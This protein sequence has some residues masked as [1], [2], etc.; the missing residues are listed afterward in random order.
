M[1]RLLPVFTLL[2]GAL[3]LAACRAEDRLVAGVWNGKLRSEGTPATRVSID[4]DARVL[5]LR[6]RGSE[7]R[8]RIEGVA[9]PGGAGVRVS[10]AERG[11]RPITSEALAAGAGRF[12]RE[13]RLSAEQLGPTSWVSL[14]FD[15]PGLVIEGLEL[16]EDAKRPKLVVLGLDGLTWRVLDPLLAAGRLPHF[17]KLVE[18]GVAGELLSEKPMLSPVVWT[19]IAAGRRHGEHG[20]HDFFDAEGR[21]V[22]STQVKARRIW[23][24]AGAEAGATVGVSGWFVSWPV[25][26]VPGFML[27]DRATEWKP[28]DLDRPL[29]FH[30]AE[31]Q[32][33]FEAVVDARRERAIEEC[34]RFTSYPLLPD[35]KQRLAPADPAYERH[36][37]L[38][39]RLFRVFLRDSSFVEASVRLQAALRPDLLFVYLRGSDNVQ[40]AFWFQRAPQESI[41]PV[42]PEEVRQFGNV[43][44]AY[45][46]WLDEALGRLMA[47]ADADTT[48]VVASDHG[49]RS[50]LRERGG[51]RRQV[52]YHEPQGVFI[53]S[54]PPFKR[55][56]RV[57]PLS[58]LDLAPLWLQ[59]VGLPAAQDMPGRVP[60]E[61][62]AR[63]IREATRVASYGGRSD[64]AVSRAGEADAGIV[65]QLK[66]LGYVQE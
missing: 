8:V 6:H 20:I 59:L 27:S 30:P 17:R 18:A 28:N 46:L 14:A 56:A 53:A 38:D 36:A 9:P 66:A 41:E 60:A 31:L 61:L 54:G 11:P 55:G 44:D 5:L 19:T 24:I 51:R 25:D 42:D 48:F 35:W 10:D 47:G 23:D 45:Y 37:F 52:A 58:V 62:F 16:V 29:S 12:R 26:P 13:L 33:P 65:E 39:T 49:F 63:E 4:G 32:A 7:A 43:I 34:R 2:G 1:R 3:A 15:R 57:K 22:N 21:L 64:A 50:M 40:H